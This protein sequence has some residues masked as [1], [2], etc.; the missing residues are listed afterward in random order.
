MSLTSFALVIL[1]CLIGGGIALFADNLGRNLGKKRLKLGRLRPRKT[2]QL[3][4]FLAGFVI[5][6]LSIAAVMWLSADVRKW[7]AEG[8]AVVDERNQLLKDVG[9]L[10]TQSSALEKQRETQLAEIEKGTRLLTDLRKRLKDSE[11]KLAASQARVQD[12]TAKAAALIR[13]SAALESKA[14][15][16]SSQVSTANRQLLE[17]KASL[18]KRKREF[19]LLDESFE[20]LSKEIADAYRENIR[21]Q[22]ENTDLRTEN[23]TAET[24]KTELQGQLDVLKTDLD[25]RKD[26]FDRQLSAKQRELELAALE[27]DARRAEVRE[28]QRNLEKMGDIWLNSRKLP[29][30]FRMGQELARVQAPANMTRAQAEDQLS[31]LVRAARSEAEQQGAKARGEI[32]PAGI[33]DRMDPDGRMLTSDMQRQRIVDRL[34]GLSEDVVLVATSSLNSFLGEPVSL[35][36]QSFRNPVVF[37]Q[38]EMVAE[39][40]IDGDRSDEV[41]VDQISEFVTTQVKERAKE[42]GMIP[43]L[44]VDQGYGVLPQNTLLELVRSARANNR[45]V[46]IQ[47]FAPS[48]IRAGDTL[49]LVYRIR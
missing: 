32:P 12:L 19:D 27:L 16:L 17:A 47:A 20:I 41:I 3:F 31:R 49:T 8:P 38:G 13:R 5:P 45:R 33:M 24:S 26:E 37:T 35:D 11:V 21:L 36:V 28:A 14:A 2:A 44:G 4:T 23:L 6:L 1:I 46:R 48:D 39:T 18:D 40:R 29:M 25:K 30:A 7:F 43:L 34:T 9:D 42:G 10:R 22:N 15:L